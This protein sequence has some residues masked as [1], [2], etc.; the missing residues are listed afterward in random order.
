MP[1]KREALGPS[2]AER[3]SPKTR[4]FR[5]AEALFHQG[6]EIRPEDRTRWLE[7]VTDDLALRD[8]VAELLHHHRADEHLSGLGQL[9]Q[10]IAASRRFAPGTAIGP[11]RLGPLLG[12][13][14]M[15]A[16][17]EAERPGLGKRVAL[18]LARS[19]SLSTESARRFEQEKRI[20]AR[21][22]HPNITQLHDAGVTAEGVPYFAMEIVQGD[23]IVAYARVHQLSVRERLE[24]FLDV[25][26]AVQLAHSQLVI[27]RDI[28]PSNVLVT[29]D[30]HVKLLDFGVAKLL[31]EANAPRITRT[32]GRIYTPGYAAPEQL[33]S[34][35]ITTATDVYQLGA[36]LYEVLVD[37]PAVDVSNLSPYD[38][39]VKVLEGDPRPPSRHG[40]GRIARDLDAIVLSAMSKRPEQRYRTADALADDV[41]RFLNSEPVR[42]R[43]GSAAYRTLKFIRRHRVRT[44]FG[45]LVA[46]ASLV[47]LGQA[48]MIASERDRARAAAAQAERE[49]MRSQ[50]VTSFLLGL[51]EASDP[52]VAQGEPLTAR[53]LL[54]RGVQ[55][56]ETFSGQPDIQATLLGTTGRIHYQLGELDAAEQLLRRALDVWGTV[57]Q[58]NPRAVSE[59]RLGMG[60]VLDLASR[61]DES[62]ETYGTLLEDL[63]EGELT[64][65]RSAALYGLFTALHAQGRAADADTVFRTWESVVE[66]VGPEKSATT[67]SKMVHLGMTLA[68][69]GDVEKGRALLRRGVAAYRALHGDRHPDLVNALNA[70]GSALAGAATPESDSV[71]SE[72][73]ELSRLLYP[74]GHPHLYLALSQ[75]ADVLAHQDR[76]EEARLAVEEALRL[77][78]RVDGPGGVGRVSRERRLAN[79]IF[80]SGES[81]EAE[82]RLREVR[83]WWIAEFGPAYPFTISVELDLA[84]VLVARRSFPDAEDLLLGAYHRAEQARGASDRY[85][86]RAA[87]LLVELYSAWGRPLLAR[88]YRKRS[89]SDPGDE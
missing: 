87:E 3:R 31:E 5:R 2:E 81:E 9:G 37:S 59:A 50:Q 56:I 51:F 25:C 19:A 72:A 69:A 15:G 28:K 44:A 85:T 41:R 89:S 65:V 11:Y 36:L 6:L 68:Y 42:A 8:R 10:R 16:V 53:Q 32:E 54:E 57:P 21:L 73:V 13:G 40:S 61:H 43:A 55:R 71:T 47:A 18:K 29:A 70:L 82:R 74:D 66:D 52:S 49:A 27:H 64:D 83:G 45:S 77:E 17:Y 58:P 30:G 26:A 34:E 20:L 7:R 84:R 1:D 46:V 80:R 60:R 24:L 39:Q 67:V 76:L 38:A 14:G 48:G 62:A 78:P 88:Q 86:L 35:P 63:P 12:E 22:Q 4:W 33:R 23:T 79:L 75:R